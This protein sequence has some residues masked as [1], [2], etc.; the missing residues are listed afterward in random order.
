[1][2]REAP[3]NTGLTDEAEVSFR[4]RRKKVMELLARS[5][6]TRSTVAK[7]NLNRLRV[8]FKRS[9]TDTAVLKVPSLYACAYS[10]CM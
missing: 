10:L 7:R 6:A 5:T 3:G 2:S 4:P 9:S 1:M 8:T